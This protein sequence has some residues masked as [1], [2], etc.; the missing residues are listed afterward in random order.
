MTHDDARS[1]ID[2]INRYQPDAIVALFIPM[3]R[4]AFPEVLWTLTHDGRLSADAH[5]W[6][7]PVLP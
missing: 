7:S 6:A 2:A 5:S 4:D 1:L 3:L